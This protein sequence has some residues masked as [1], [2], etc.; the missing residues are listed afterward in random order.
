MPLHESL[1]DITTSFLPETLP[2]E[3]RTKPRYF[4]R[5]TKL[6]AEQTIGFLLSSVASSIKN[7]LRGHSQQFLTTQCICPL[8]S[9]YQHIHFTNVQKTRYKISDSAFHDIFCELVD[10]VYTHWDDEEYNFYDMAVV[11]FD[12]SQFTLPGS[13]EIRQE[14]DEETPILKIGGRYFPQALVMTAFDVFRKIP[15]GRTISHT[16]SSERTE[17][18]KMLDDLV[19]KTL[20]VLDRGYY[21]YEVFNRIMFE[22]KHEFLAKV[23]MTNS[24][25]EVAAFVATGEAEGVITI[26]PTESY[27]RKLKSGKAD[28]VDNLEPLTL[29]IIRTKLG[30]DEFILLTSLLDL[31]KHS[32]DSFVELYQARWEVENYYR[33]EKMWLEVEDF[34]TE[35]VLG[36]KQELF[37]TMIMSIVTRVSLYLEELKNSKNGVPQFYNAI[38]SMARAV[39]RMIALGLE[40]C[41]IFLQNLLDAIILT[42]YYPSKVRRSFERISRKPH[43]KWKASALTKI[44]NMK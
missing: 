41:K 19:V 20:A 21:G 7:G 37:A 34:M 4:T 27:L 28:K 11:A 1:E 38:T 44:K 2:T 16:K 22:T 39:P 17:L 40:R 26:S 33:D 25:K 9:D 31:E 14:F 18:L 42:R 8:L 23:P 12:G 10:S 15:V 36:V 29:R 43:N 32:T 5:E 6:T 30:E 35:S 13:D 24:F 3:Y